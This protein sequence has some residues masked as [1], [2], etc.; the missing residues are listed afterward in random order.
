MRKRHAVAAAAAVLVLVGGFGI[1]Q[2]GHADEIVVRVY[3]RA[4]HD[5][6]NWDTNEER[7]YRSYLEGRHE[8]YREY[9]RINRKHQREYWHWRHEHPDADR[10]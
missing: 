6:H 5:Y 9:R 1:S 3:D 7:V 10:H 4:H 2:S 8:A